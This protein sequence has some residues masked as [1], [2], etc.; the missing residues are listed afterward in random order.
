[1]RELS[2]GQKV[3]A[4]RQKL[5]LTIPQL[6]DLTGLSRGFI[7]QVENN[8]VSLS[9]DS[10]Q[11]LASALKIPVKNLL[12][13]EPFPPDVTR[14]NERPSIKYGNEPEIELLS[15]P[16]GRQLQI[17]MVEL[18]A[19]YQAGN[20]AHS[21]E[22]EEWIIVLSGKVKISQ[23]DFSAILEEGDSIHWDGSHPHLCQNGSDTPAKIIAALTPPAML[24]VSKIE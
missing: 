1:M 21:H 19:G 9:L 5:N 16:F 6:A 22:G 10:L 20:C 24:P 11:K 18:P 8:K 2:L 15:T 14:K 17:M 4:F 7:S 12:E 23:G 3:K 13:D